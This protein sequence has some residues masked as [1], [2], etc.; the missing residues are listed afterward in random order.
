MVKS[1]L[2]EKPD[3]Y[4][5][6]RVSQYRLAAH[7][8]SALVLYSAS[9]WTGLSLLLPRHKVCQESKAQGHVSSECCG[10]GVKGDCASGLVSIPDSDLMLCYKS[11]FL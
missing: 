5:I 2:E 6:P 7:L 8:G 4:D 9:L 1:G 10:W 3:S 11:P